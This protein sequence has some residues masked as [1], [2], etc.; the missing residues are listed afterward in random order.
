MGIFMELQEAGIPKDLKVSLHPGLRAPTL[1]F[2]SPVLSDMPTVSVQ[3]WGSNSL[4][5][6][7]DLLHLSFTTYTKVSYAL[8]FPS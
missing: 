4:P 5:T 1:E 2:L 7:Q 8:L 6:S 3:T